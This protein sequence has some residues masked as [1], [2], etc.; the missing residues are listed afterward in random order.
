MKWAR[1]TVAFNL[2]TYKKKYVGEQYRNEKTQVVML[3][4]YPDVWTGNSE[5]NQTA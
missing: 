2:A 3:V 1:A 4:S 5:N